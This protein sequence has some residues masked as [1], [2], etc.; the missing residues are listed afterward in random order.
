MGNKIQQENSRAVMA[1]KN[2]KLAIDNSTA[3][4]SDQLIKENF[5]KFPA[6]TQRALAELAAQKQIEL[7]M[8]FKQDQLTHTNA[9]IDTQRFINT[10]AQQQFTNARFSSRMDVKTATGNMH[11]EVGNKASSYCYV[12][13]ATYQNIN[14]PNVIILRDYRDRF[15]RKSVWGR[16][17]IT[18]YYKIGKYLAIFPENIPFVRTASK[19][20]LDELVVRIIK[21]YYL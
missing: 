15:L 21:K 5:N 14:H 3:S 9:D 18:V 12:A 6:E 7:E 16:I 4:L 20:L 8:K 10:A 17:F 19:R 13:T 2:N 1:Q 11:M